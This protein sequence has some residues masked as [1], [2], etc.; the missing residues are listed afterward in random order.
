MNNDKIHDLVRRY[1]NGDKLATAE[2]IKNFGALIYSIVEKYKKD[3]APVTKQDIYNHGVVTFLRLTSAYDFSKGIDFP[4]YIKRH[5]E[6]TFTD[7][8][9]EV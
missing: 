8:I 9:G 4:G 2:L 1:H 3:I 6:F 5:F 7:T